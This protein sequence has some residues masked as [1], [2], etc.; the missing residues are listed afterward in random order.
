MAIVERVWKYWKVPW[1]Q[2]A[3]GEFYWSYS[4]SNQS[5]CFFLFS[6]NVENFIDA[7]DFTR[8]L[9]LLFIAVLRLL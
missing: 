2:S 9:K 4:S 8:A 6:N 3:L 5:N 7:A 1:A